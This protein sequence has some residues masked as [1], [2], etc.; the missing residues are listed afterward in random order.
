[1]KALEVMQA[2]LESHMLMV[3]LAPSKRSDRREWDQ[4]RVCMDVPPKWYRD[5]CNR[6]VSSRQ[7]RRGKFDT[8]IKRA[9]ILRLLERLIENPKASSKYSTEIMKIAG[10]L[11]YDAIPRAV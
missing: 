9:N 6:H 1:M 10:K 4:I 11:K 5:L 7:I 2:E 3:V 8:K